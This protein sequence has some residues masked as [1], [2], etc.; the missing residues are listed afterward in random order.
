LR[1]NRKILFLSIASGILLFLSFPKHGTGIMAWVALIPLFFALRDA[2][3]FRDGLIA[4]FAAGL[5]FNIG[6][7]Y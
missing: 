1:I 7:M 2:D 4:G 6:L 5:T 3:N